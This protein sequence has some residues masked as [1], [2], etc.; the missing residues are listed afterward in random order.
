MKMRKAK[1][2]VHCEVLYERFLKIN[3]TYETTQDSRFQKSILK[4]SVS[5]G[6]LQQQKLCKLTESSGT[7]I[8][9]S[10]NSQHILLNTPLPQLSKNRKI[11][12]LKTSYTKYSLQ[13]CTVLTV[14]D[15]YLLETQISLAQLLCCTES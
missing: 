7:F 15:V 10:H 2:V 13:F 6:S 4:P 1:V 14:F 5:L 3:E 9:H 8:F 11:I 12:K